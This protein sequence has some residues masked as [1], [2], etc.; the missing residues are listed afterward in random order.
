MDLYKK[1]DFKR[2]N[3]LIKKDLKTIGD[4]LISMKELYIY[5]PYDYTEKNLAEIDNTCKLLGIF[6]IA[7]SN[8]NYTLATI[9]TLIYT[10][11]SSIDTIDIDGVS[12]YRLTYEAKDVIID[13][14]NVI[15][16]LDMAY[17][18][19]NLMMINGKVPWFIEYIDLLKI[20]NNFNKYTG[21]KVALFSDIMKIFIRISAREKGKLDINYSNILNLE[22][23]LKTKEIEWIGLSNIYYTFNS[24]LSK[25]G[26]SY[27]KKALIST[28]VT[29]EKEPTELENILRK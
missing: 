15:L 22:K 18:V 27:F 4:T 16:E 20:F 9:P 21:S 24:T 3:T 10:T 19:F 1:K 8:N 6:I 14:L 25:V 7:D 5:F 28:M 13:N 2:N 29:P 26:G 11:P 23:D 17:N 12:Y